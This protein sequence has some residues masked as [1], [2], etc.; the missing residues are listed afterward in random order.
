ML[1][2]KE[3]KPF[4]VER[5]DLAHRAVDYPRWATADA[6]Y[7]IVY[8]HVRLPTFQKQER[9]LSWLRR[10]RS[11]LRVRHIFALAQLPA[12]GLDLS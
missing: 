10:C 9:H 8:E 4:H 2:R 11:V 12:C 1:G 7:D 5:W 6:V 3:L